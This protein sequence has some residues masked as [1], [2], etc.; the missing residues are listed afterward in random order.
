MTEESGS[1]RERNTRPIAEKSTRILTAVLR[2]MHN[3]KGME[4][5]IA[6]LYHKAFALSV[7]RLADIRFNRPGVEQN[8]CPLNSF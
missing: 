5:K 7:G 4:N 2:C 6:R 1:G 3:G 8:V